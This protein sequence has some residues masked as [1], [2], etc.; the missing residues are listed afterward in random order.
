[1]RKEKEYQY[2]KEI[3]ESRKK[4]EL[5]EQEKVQL[6]ND[7][8]FFQEELQKVLH[9]KSWKL[10]KPLRFVTS[11]ISKNSFNE[12]LDASVVVQTDYHSIPSYTSEYQENIVFDAFTP[13]V[14]TLAFYLPQYHEIAENNAWWGKGFTEWTNTKKSKPLFDGHY[15]PR[16]PHEDIGYYNLEDIEVLKK[17]VQ[18]AK[19]HGLY[20]FA[21]YYYWFSGK[22]L[23]E[24]PVDLLLKHPEIDFPFVL[25]WANENWT[26]TWDGLEKEVL[27]SQEYREE[28]PYLFIKDWKKYVDDPRYIRIEG[29][30]V[31][32]V[33]NPG[34]IKKFSD[35][36]KKWREASKDLGIGEIIIWSK[37]DIARNDVTNSEF[38]D[39][40]FDFAPHGFTLPNDEITGIQN[41]SNIVN[42]SK[43]VSFLGETYDNH[44]PLRPF[45]YSVTMGWDN[46][47]RRQTGFKIYYNYSLESFY[48]WSTLAIK[49][50]Y[51]NSF[52]N[53]FFLVNAWNEWGE[54]TYLEPDKKY[55]YAN[56]N[57]L[58]KA[59][60]GI[61]FRANFKVFTGKKSL[62][63][64]MKKIAV[65]CH[66]F[67]V[68]ILEEILQYLNHISVAYD[69]YISTD[70]EEK[71]KKILEILD[72]YSIHYY[73]VEIYENRGR[74]ILPML[75][76]M[77]DRISNYDY[78]LHL[79]TKKSVSLD[80]G[81]NWRQYLFDHLLGSTEYVN[82]ILDTF[83]KQ[84][85]LGLI[86][87]IPHKA[88]FYQLINPNGSIG[89]NQEYLEKLF[90]DL[91]LSKDKIS[92][93]MTF[94]HGSMFWAKTAAIKD[95]FQCYDES[96]F[97]NE[98]GQLDGT[99][100]HAIERVFDVL[101]EK[102][103]YET[104]EVLNKK[105]KNL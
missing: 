37:N 4:M 95:L 50:L 54:G 76:Q 67:Y 85:N 82:S 12:S 60:C 44:Y 73:E 10:T 20:G 84:E 7:L 83:E 91:S 78:F 43:L 3:F 48:T 87:P 42:Y 86:Y 25:C 26:R 9:S 22:R 46:A 77:K 89:G 2:R 99:Y 23:L 81:E 59:I 69:L 32:M 80:N 40:E 64:F 5:L 14:K 11:K 97:A 98:N 74:D 92:K 27:I 102:N 55:G 36:C 63:K 65:Q 96:S 16:E 49:K 75:L 24:K 101:A 90:S 47:A 100:A 66:V 15:M 8:N 17:Q 1:M 30:P 104:L 33:Y 53:T 56:I 19:Q 58:S 18:L 70:S 21:F 52:E 51:Q 93:Q 88:S 41:A 72:N 45:Q 29:K 39:G 68:D 71:K 35:V 105:G 38:V 34:A 61:P 62:P 103:G 57:T 79:H 6:R 13:L 94:P 31:L 28:D